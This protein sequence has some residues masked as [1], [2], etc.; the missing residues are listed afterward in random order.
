MARAERCGEPMS[1]E[2][3]VAVD[4]RPARP[5]RRTMP[6][7]RGCRRCDDRG[8]S[9]RRRSCSRLQTVAAGTITRMGRGVVGEVELRGCA[10]WLGNGDRRHRAGRR[11]HV[12]SGRCRTFSRA[13]RPVRS[14]VWTSRGLH[15]AV[16][17]WS[18]TRPVIGQ[19][20][21]IPWSAIGVGLDATGGAIG[22]AIGRWLAPGCSFWLEA[23]AHGCLL[24]LRGEPPWSLAAVGSVLAWR[25]GCSRRLR[26]R[27][28]IG[29]SARGCDDG[30]PRASLIGRCGGNV[31]PEAKGWSA[32]GEQAGVHLVAPRLVKSSAPGPGWPWPWGGVLGELEADAASGRCSGQRRAS[33]G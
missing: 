10:G 5:S 9:S 1:S 12:H 14:E 32:A 16:A 24:G 33:P 18:I 23:A 7:R 11:G 22:G 21:R 8:G 2:R 29:H 25:R 6:I 26:L 19:R 20:A 30:R 27:R 17:A 3:G 28:S 4:R 31:A 15:A 13:C